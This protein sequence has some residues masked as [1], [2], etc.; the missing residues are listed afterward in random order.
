MKFHLQPSHLVSGWQVIHLALKEP[1]RHAVLHQEAKF[2]HPTYLSTM[3]N[4]T[5]PKPQLTIAPGKFWPLI[6]WL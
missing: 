3:V 6:A 4:G 2:K 1:S 5:D